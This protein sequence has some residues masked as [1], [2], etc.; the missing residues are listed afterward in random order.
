A[1]EQRAGRIVRHHPFPFRPLKQITS[2]TVVGRSSLELAEARVAVYSPHTA[3]DAAREGIDEGVAEQLGLQNSRTLGAVHSEE[4]P[5]GSGRWGDL[6]RGM[7]LGDLATRLKESL[8][9]PYAQI[10]GSLDAPVTRLGIAC[11]SGG[12]LLTLAREARC[13]VFLT[14]E[15]SFHRC[16]EAEADGIAMVLIGH[17]ASERFAVERLAERLAARFPQLRV[18]ASERERD[19]LTWL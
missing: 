16:L 11:G 19:P 13:D 10:V 18:W 5:L 3:F 15:A 4:L 8:R 17:Y 6:Q 14:G 7:T 1:V 12:E 9:L 2:P